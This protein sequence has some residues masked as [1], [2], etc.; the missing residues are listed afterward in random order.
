MM[1]YKGYIGQIT[2]DD[3]AKLF[4]GEVIGLKDLITFRGKSVEELEK[5]LQESVDFY[6]AWCKKEGTEPEKSFSGNLHVR[7]PS[8]LHAKLSKVASLQGV[9]LNSF[10]VETLSKV[11]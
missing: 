6:I 2:Y 3:E 11:Q 10:V 9:S 4:H 5:S 7:I 8:K 1:T